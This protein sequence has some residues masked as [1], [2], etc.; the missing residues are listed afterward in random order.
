MICFSGKDP[1]KFKNGLDPKSLRIK[2]R[3]YSQDFSVV[4]TTLIY[5]YLILDL[6]GVPNIKVTR[7][8]SVGAIS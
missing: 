5:V 4:R 2:P 3:S 1:G 6:R 7:G 8:N